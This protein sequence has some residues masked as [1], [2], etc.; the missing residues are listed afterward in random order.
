MFRD[1][2]TRFWEA[3]LFM[4]VPLSILIAVAMVALRSGG[5][6]E[7][8]GQTFWICLTIP[9]EYVRRNPLAKRL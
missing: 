5:L 9:Y 3:G 2:E 1:K 8:A 6:D 4:A 7:H